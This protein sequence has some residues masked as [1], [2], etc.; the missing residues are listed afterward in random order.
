MIDIYNSNNPEGAANAI[1]DYAS[2]MWSANGDMAD[3]ITVIVV[4]FEQ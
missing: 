1:K 4:F 2:K 3:D